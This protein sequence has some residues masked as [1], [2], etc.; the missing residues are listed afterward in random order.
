[1]DQGSLVSLD[2][3]IDTAILQELERSG[4]RVVVAFWGK[5]EEYGAWRFFLAAPEF[6]GMDRFE[7]YKRIA[8]ARSPGLV[9]NEHVI[10]ILSMDNPIVTGVLRLTMHNKQ[11]HGARLDGLSFGPHLIEE[12]ILERAA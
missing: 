10:T 5:L 9:F 7:A 8:A 2:K 1:M 6:D 4:I 3:N 12:G 11:V